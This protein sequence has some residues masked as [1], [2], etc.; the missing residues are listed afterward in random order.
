MRIA[1]DLD[2]T[3][4]PA[5]RRLEPGIERPSI[6]ARMYSRDRLRAGSRELLCDLH[7]QGHE[8]WIYTTSLRTPARVSWWFR[9][10]GVSI[11]GVINQ[12]RHDRTMA[13]LTLGHPPS[14]HPPSFG[15]D[16]LVDDSAGV[17]AEG[18]EHGF[19]V[20]EVNPDDEEWTSRVRQAVE[21]TG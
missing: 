13:G 4:V 21:L 19:C 18:R 2:D 14:K 6:L 12:Q 15:I 8:I 17:A 16:L 11:G 5:V 1:F 7:A 20:V 10:Y 9:L 3:L